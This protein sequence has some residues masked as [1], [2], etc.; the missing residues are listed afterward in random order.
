MYKS[1]L[2]VDSRPT[3]LFMNEK[4]DELRNNRS[5]RWDHGNLQSYYDYTGHFLYPLYNSLLHRCNSV[6]SS[7]CAA[8]FIELIY[9]STIC[10]LKTAT[11]KFIPFARPSVYKP[12][13][14]ENLK[15][16]KAQAMDSYKIWELAGKPR[17][18]TIFDMKCRDKLNYKK[19]IRKEKKKTDLCISDSLYES[20]LNK[21]S[22]QFWKTWNNK[23][24]NKKD[25]KI[26][27]VGGGSDEEI[28]HKFAEHFKKCCTPNSHNFNTKKKEKFYSLMKDYSGDLKST[29]QLIISAELICISVD[30]LN[31]GRAAGLDGIVTEHIVN[32]HPIIYSLLSKL[33]NFILYTGYVPSDFGKGIM[34]P[35]PKSQQANKANSI[36]NFRGITL[37]PIVSKIFEHCL[38]ELMNE[39]LFTSDNQFGFKAKLSCS[40][41]IFS[42]KEV[43]D[44]YV[45]H[46]SSV[47]VC[48]IDVS[49]AFDKLNHYVL[50]MKLMKRHVPIKFVNVLLNWYTKVLISVKWNNL[51]SDYF[52][53]T[54]GIR[55]GGILSPVL[56]LVYVDD[57]LEKLAKM[58][59]RILGHHVGALMYADDLILLSPMLYELQSMLNVCKLELDLLDLKLNAS[60]SVCL[61]FG[62]AYKRKCT[63]LTLEGEMIPWVSEARYLGVFLISGTKFG[64][65]LDKAKAKFYR[66]SNA[67]LSKLGYQKNPAVALNLIASIALPSLLYGLE[68]L[69]LNVSQKTSLSHPWNRTFM[70]I[71]STFDKNV[72]K[73]C[74]Y[75][76]GFLPFLYVLDMRRI[77][78]L[79]K[80][81]SIENDTVN[82][83]KML[84]KE[85]IPAIAERYVPGINANYFIKNY[86]TILLQCFSADVV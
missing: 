46:D 64:C 75:Y 31:S 29:K 20:L 10:V 45:N 42:M 77:E 82:V 11:E 53:V 43:V 14:G 47:N 8:E 4:S 26:E 67:I 37:S 85:I 41:A 18:G 76:G 15:L 35:I 30:K 69:T 40:H 3:T 54:A 78:F 52:P 60:K 57:L 12:W 25:A 17:N 6:E 81:Q 55:Q 13:W 48:L 22:T 59:C 51:F 21:D 62:K 80:L 44:Y 16:L 56:F 86:K 24:V 73:Q 71:Y 2:S 39:Y 83:A 5:L 50:F 38:L 49:K 84:N 61:R 63:N 70:K 32:C 74:Q 66:S 28:A 1:S 58:G 65:N 72:I 36:E 27:I 7:E 33:F 68:T 23:V 19:E 34:V 9:S 79:I